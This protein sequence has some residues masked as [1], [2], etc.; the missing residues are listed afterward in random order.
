[1]DGHRYVASDSGIVTI[2]VADAAGVTRK[3]MLRLKIGESVEDR[4][5]AK[6]AEVAGETGVRVIRN[7]SPADKTAEF[8]AAACACR[9]LRGRRR[10]RASTIKAREEVDARQRVEPKPGLGPVRA[11]A[12]G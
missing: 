2:F 3:H 8:A 4:V 9:R 7:G 10:G 5:R 12:S 11:W 1:M 6:L